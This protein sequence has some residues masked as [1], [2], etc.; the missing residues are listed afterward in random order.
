[1]DDFWGINTVA[2]WWCEYTSGGSGIGR[3]VGRGLSTSPTWM[4]LRPFLV[5]IGLVTMERL[6]ALHA[7]VVNGTIARIE[8]GDSAVP[9]GRIGRPAA[10]HPGLPA[11]IL[12]PDEAYEGLMIS[13]DFEGEVPSVVYAS[14]AI[15]VALLACEPA[16]STFAVVDRRAVMT[17]KAPEQGMY[18]ALWW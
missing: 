7:H 9:S 2:D 3:I 13:V 16:A 1:M 4:V 12:R 17:A 5:D 14:K 18:F 10:E 8:Y 6:L 15:D 11:L